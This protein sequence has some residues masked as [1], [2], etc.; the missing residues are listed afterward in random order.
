MCEEKYLKAL[1]P[2]SR[3]AL[4]QNEVQLPA[5]PFR[6][7]RQDRKFRDMEMVDSLL[8]H[9]K[10]AKNDCS[11]LEEG[12]RKF[13]SREHFLIEMREG[14]AYVL[15]DRGSALGTLVEGELIGGE[16]KGGEALLNDGAVIIPGGQG[17]PYVF[18]FEVRKNDS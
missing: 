12:K 7:G 16:K 14:K 17:S 13:L 10:T 15:V 6:V 8:N 1:T 5:L 11:I 18:R 3:K 2:A 9:D 4:G